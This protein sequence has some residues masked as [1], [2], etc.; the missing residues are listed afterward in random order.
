MRAS[1]FGLSRLPQKTGF[2]SQGL[3]WMLIILYCGAGPATVWIYYYGF[4]NWKKTRMKMA[5]GAQLT[6]ARRQEAGKGEGG[7]R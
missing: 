6:V 2:I 3:M 5:K 4:S 7:K 1:Y